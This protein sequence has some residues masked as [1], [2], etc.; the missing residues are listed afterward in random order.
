MRGRRSMIFAAS[1]TPRAA[2]CLRIRRDRCYRV[3]SV[4]RPEAGLER[5][6]TRAQ[7]E[8]VRLLVEGK[9]HVEIALVRHRSTRT[10]AN[11]LG[12]VFRKLGVSGRSELIR[13]LIVQSPETPCSAPPVSTPQPAAWLSEPRLAVR[14]YRS[15]ARRVS[16]GPSLVV[17]RSA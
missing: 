14:R 6:L 3:I 15:R 9:S 4:T 5:V 17:P 1:T 10:I 16:A 13:R 7:Y 2:N 8:V 11:Q 12:A